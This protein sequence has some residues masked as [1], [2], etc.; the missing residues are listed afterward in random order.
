MNKR[1]VGKLRQPHIHWLAS[2]KIFYILVPLKCGCLINEF[3]LLFSSSQDLKYLLNNL[4]CLSIIS[5]KYTPI[6]YKRYYFIIFLLMKSS[7]NIFYF[8]NCI[9]PDYMAPESPEEFWKNSHFENM[10]AVRVKTHFGK[11]P[12]KMMH[13]QPWKK[14]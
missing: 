7:E 9:L 5:L 12:L 4:S 13:F 14:T 11:L 6:Q 10:K 2:I 1:S 8:L 3:F